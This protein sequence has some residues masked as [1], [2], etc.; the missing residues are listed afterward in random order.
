MKK[1]NH[2]NAAASCPK[3]LSIRRQMNVPATPSGDAAG[4]ECK[5]GWSSCEAIEEQKGK[6]D[7]QA[8]T[9]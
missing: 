6:A 5:A 8:T 9:K 1:L 4:S 2:S 3:A 7:F